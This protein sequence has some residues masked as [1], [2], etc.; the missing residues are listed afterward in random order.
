MSNQFDVIVA[1]VGSMGS[2]TCYH[3]AKRGIKVLGLEQ[4]DVPHARG[5]GHGHSRVIRL[6]YFEHPDYVPLL[7]RAY[8]N[9]RTLEK[10]AGIDILHVTGGVYMGKPT[11]ELIE[12]SLRAQKQHNIEHKELSHADLAAQYPMF[13]LPKDYVG[14]YE[15]AVGYVLPEQ[16]ISSCVIEALRRGATIHGH[17]PVLSWSSDSSGVRVKTHKAEYTA[18]KLIFTG[19]AWSDRLITGLGIPLKVTRQVLAWVWPKNPDIFQSGRLPVWMIDHGTGGQHYGFPMVKEIPGFKL[20]YHSLGTPTDPDKVLRDPQPGDEETFRPLLQQMI[21]DADGPTLAIRTCIYTNSP[22]GH[23][24][25]DNHPTA[26]NVSIAC[27]FSGHGFKF[28]SVIGE[29][30]ADL[31][32]QGK[33]PLPAQ[34]LGLKRFT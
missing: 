21:P 32:T 29:I 8:E 19:G 13:K 5:A 26:S 7:K 12:G 20:A 25:L 15:N 9:W 22:D 27:G 17:E 23:F 16:A 14:M 31:A 2:S 28:A 1:G 24:I 34:F 30:M 33:T 18:K 11:S 3:L 6:A 10:D 4:F